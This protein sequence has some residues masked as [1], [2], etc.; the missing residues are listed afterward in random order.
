[1]LAG[2]MVKRTEHA[3]LSRETVRRRLKEN[4]LK[5]WQQDM[6]C[7]PQV[8]GQTGPPPFH[9]E[10]FQRRRESSEPCEFC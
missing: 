2:E 3:E 6:W 9:G 4:Q 5:P 10:P 8:P 1:L 7:I